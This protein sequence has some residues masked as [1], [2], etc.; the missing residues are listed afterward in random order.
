MA[1]RCAK[2]VCT[3]GPA[4]RSPAQLRRLAEAG[5]DVARLNFSHGAHADH[6]AVIAALRQIA[7]D[8]GRPIAILQD[9]QGPKM[10]IGAIAA[11]GRVELQD[12]A[13]FVIT[14]R[15]VSGDGSCVSTD[16]A[17]LPQEVRG[18][19]E[20]LLSDG[21]IRLVVRAV[22]A[23]DVTCEVANAGTLRERAGMNLPG[24]E[25][26]TPSLTVKDRRDL[27]F[28][29]EQGVDYVALS[30][31]RR[32][33]DL[34]EL[35]GIMEAAGTDCG[36]I[37][38]LEKPQA[39]DRLDAILDA[40]DAV[41]IARGDLGVELSPERVPFVQKQVIARA[42]M[43]KVP[44]ITATQML[45]SMIDH[46]RPTRAEASDV[47]NAVLDG[48][49]AV[50]LSGETA[51]GHHPLEATRMMHR[52][53]SE[54]ETSAA[55]GAYPESVRA[56]RADDSPVG[57]TDA[58]AGAACRMAR[59]VKAGAIIVFTRSGFTAQ[60]ISKG[61]PHTPI[62]AFTSSDSVSRRLSLYWGVRARRGEL[63]PDGD[64]MIRAAD[65]ELLADGTLRHGDTVVVLAG[66]PSLQLR[67]STSW[68][69]L[70]RVGHAQ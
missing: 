14:T 38:K 18:G 66:S 16:Y 44:V 58:L 8:L 51:I 23:T 12:G 32:P 52:I 3:I 17:Q 25:L 7:V 46:P 10:R 55:G 39:I 2:I 40:A 35:R 61:R 56:R 67:G 53:V 28:G 43:L 4:T 33:E 30:F 5:M 9:L 41:M 11:G 1:E 37:A 57:F 47:A 50:M 69:E 21:L 59:Q 70:H 45:E 26:D 19:D 36:V 20:I 34:H 13:S 65:R 63:H 24:V 42:A 27:Q 31:V 64:R 15:A 68:L 62:I 49:D 60:L 29:L 22:E 54:A 6:A 48:T